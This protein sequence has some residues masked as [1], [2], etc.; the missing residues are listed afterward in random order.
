MQ[1]LLPKSLFGGSRQFFS[2]VRVPSQGGSA[3]L[4]RGSQLHRQRSMQLTEE[5]LEESDYFYIELDECNCLQGSSRF[6]DDCCYCVKIF[7]KLRY[8]AYMTKDYLHGPIGNQRSSGVLFIPMVDGADYTKGLGGYLHFPPDGEERFGLYSK[9]PGEWRVNRETLNREYVGQ[10]QF[11]VCVPNDGAPHTVRIEFYKELYD[12]F[13][14]GAHRY[15][16]ANEVKVECSPCTYHVV[17]YWHCCGSRGVVGPPCNQGGCC[18]DI[19]LQ[20]S[21]GMTDEGCIAGW[22]LLTGKRGSPELTPFT[23]NGKLVRGSSS[24]ESV[25]NSA[26]GIRPI[27]TPLP[28]ELMLT[29][30][31]LEELKGADRMIVRL[32][33]TCGKPWDYEVPLQG[34]EYRRDRSAA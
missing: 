16:G 31:N 14:L 7:I 2:S 10:T 27:Y 20:Q 1:L 11:K 5:L 33:D 24:G 23:K 19:V 6:T 9:N 18:V 17:A 15:L 30:L 12:G 8:S 29:H 13:G 22:E 21:G 34:C 32:Y 25:F 4:L 26:I 3:T 28:Q